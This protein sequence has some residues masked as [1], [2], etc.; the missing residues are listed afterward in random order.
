[1]DPDPG[2]VDSVVGA[3]WLLVDA[4]RVVGRVVTEGE[5]PLQKFSRQHVPVQLVSVWPNWFARVLMTV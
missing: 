1:M 3:D 2:F 4:E 5:G